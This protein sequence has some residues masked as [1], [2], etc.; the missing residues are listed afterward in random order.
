MGQRYLCLAGHCAILPGLCMITMAGTLLPWDIQKKSRW[1][2]GTQVHLLAPQLRCEVAGETALRD[3]VDSLGHQAT[4][5]SS[6]GLPVKSYEDVFLLDP[7]LLPG[8]QRVPLCLSNPPQ[9]VR[10]SLPPFS[11]PFLCSKLGEQASLLV[12]SGNGPAE[13]AA[14]TSHYVG[15]CASAVVPGQL[16]HLHLAQ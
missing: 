8:Q 3:R 5:V 15:L 16:L 7:L 13:A 11:A 9:Q 2:L 6:S 10:V 4:R 1:C 14:P 12:F